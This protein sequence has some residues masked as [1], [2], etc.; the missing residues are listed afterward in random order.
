MHAWHWQLA[1]VAALTVAGAQGPAACMLLQSKRIVR[2][3]VRMTA[4]QVSLSAP[5][6]GCAHRCLQFTRCRLCIGRWRCSAW[7]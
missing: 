6:T 3:G 7:L 4:Q 5:E 2:L 1:Q